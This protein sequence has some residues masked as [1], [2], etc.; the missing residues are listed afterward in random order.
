MTALGGL[1]LLAFSSLT[2]PLVAADWI[3]RAL[4]ERVFT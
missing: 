3:Q 2:V 4:I 1:V